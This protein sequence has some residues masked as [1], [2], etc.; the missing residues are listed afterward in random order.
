MT[1][2]AIWEQFFKG[3]A[4]R[5]SSI[6]LYR[7]WALFHLIVGYPLVVVP[8]FYQVFIAEKL[9]PGFAALMDVVQVIWVGLHFVLLT[10]ILLLAWLTRPGA[11]SSHRSLSNL[12]ALSAVCDLITTLLFALQ[13]GFLNTAPHFVIFTI[14]VLTRIFYPYRVAAAGALSVLTSLLGLQ[15][16]SF[17]ARNL[18]A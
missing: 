13:V 12:T 11:H 5:P 4:E 9:V 3:C 15:R 6:T 18:P 17:T 10:T 8:A 16:F 7:T 1:Q 2:Y 14:I